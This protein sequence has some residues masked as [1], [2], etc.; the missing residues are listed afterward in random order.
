[1]EA[2]PSAGFCINDGGGM[3]ESSSDDGG[4]G[5]RG[6]PKKDPEDRRTISHGLYLSEKEKRELERRAD[7]AGL[8]V[9][10]YLRRKALGGKSV[11]AKTDQKTRSELRSIGINLNQLARQ[12]NQGNLEEV[13]EA[14]EEGIE[15]L[16]EALERIE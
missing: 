9:N 15:D 6:R 12:A 3:S 2:A 10:E 14:V 7:A 11:Q 13:A 5:Q 4:S 8:S 1:L 16:R